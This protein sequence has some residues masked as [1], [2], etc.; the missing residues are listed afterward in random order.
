HWRPPFSFEGAPSP[1]S[2][3]SRGGHCT[4]LPTA[5]RCFGPCRIE[6]RMPGRALGSR[7]FGRNGRA[8]RRRTAFVAQLSG[9][10]KRRAGRNTWARAWAWANSR[11]ALP[12]SLPALGAPRYAG[13]QDCHPTI[14]EIHAG[15]QAVIRQRGK[16]RL[17]RRG[18][19][20]GRSGILQSV[21]QIAEY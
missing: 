19:A 3:T 6:L 1:L 4:I 12:H 17:W 11:P 20:V 14:P 2:T 21:N 16:S 5:W 7:P 18:S 9:G 8:G 10:N 15:G 13:L